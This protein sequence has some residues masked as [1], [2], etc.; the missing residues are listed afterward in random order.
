MS[1]CLCILE[2]IK[3]HFPEHH[4]WFRVSSHLNTVKWMISFHCLILLSCC[5]N[6]KCYLAQIYMTH[7]YIIM[8]PE[9]QSDLTLLYKEG[10][11][12]KARSLMC[13]LFVQATQQ[14][15][16]SYFIKYSQHQVYYSYYTLKNSGLF[17]PNFGS[18]MDKPTHWGYI[19]KIT[20]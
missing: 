1:A 4:S 5:M 16:K 12:K 17:S 18:N 7:K 15:L 2:Q 10:L 9:V 6:M 19:F 8:G 20:F 3:I 14:H 11:K 13:R